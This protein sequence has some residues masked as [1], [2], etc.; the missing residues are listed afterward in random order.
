MMFARV[1][2]TSGNRD[3]L[4]HHVKSK[5]CPEL[6]LRPLNAEEP[7]QATVHPGWSQRRRDPDFVLEVVAGN[8]APSWQKVGRE[9]WRGG[10]RRWG[11]S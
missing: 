6:G 9:A 3:R 2:A 8:T 7:K 11:G 10:G 1:R 4:E 5:V